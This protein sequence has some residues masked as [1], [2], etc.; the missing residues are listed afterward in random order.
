MSKPGDVD[1]I[2]YFMSKLA[3]DVVSDGQSPV[4]VHKT[5]VSRLPVIAMAVGPIQTKGRLMKK[6]DEKIEETLSWQNKE[7]TDSQKTRA[8]GTMGDQVLTNLAT[9]LGGFVPYVG[10]IE[11]A[12]CLLEPLTK[13]SE[14][15]E[16]CVRDAAVK[17][18]KLV[19]QEVFSASYTNDQDSEWIKRQSFVEKLLAFVLKEHSKDQFFTKQISVCALAAVAFDATK[20]APLQH[21]FS[22]GNVENVQDL[23]VLRFKDLQDGHD[24]MLRRATAEN[25]RDMACVC[26]PERTWKDLKPIWET[27]IHDTQQDSIR[28]HAIKAASCIFTNQTNDGGAMNEQ[29]VKC[30]KSLELCGNDKAWQVRQAV[31]RALPEV[32]LHAKCLDE[33][34][35]KEIGS[36]YMRLLNDQE[37]E[38]WSA[39]ALRSAAAAK[40]FGDAVLTEEIFLT[41]KKH[42]L[43]P[44]QEGL[45]RIQLAES[46]LEMGYPLGPQKSKQFFLTAE[47]EY[48]DKT[49]LNKLFEEEGDTNFRLAIIRKLKALFEEDLIPL[50]NAMDVV[51]KVSEMCRSKNWRIRHGALELTPWVAKNVPTW[52]DPACKFCDDKHGFLMDHCFDNTAEVRRMWVEVSAEIIKQDKNGVEWYKKNVAP[53]L[54]KCTEQ[55]NYLHKA[56]LLNALSKLVPMLKGNDDLF[57]PLI[58][59]ALL[60]ADS[61]VPNLK[62]LV[63]KTLG[64]V[65]D[66]CNPSQQAEITNVLKTLQS[67]ADV[68]VRENALA[69][70]QRST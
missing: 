36:M 22:S 38:V 8:T 12:E 53:V 70:E 44:E 18:I 24:P 6:L 63:A 68:D 49:L 10:G 33:A 37:T 45:R 35:R 3:V 28:S 9:T 25:I 15:H 2:D 1:E 50:A 32:V 19:Y 40:N 13:L 58:S 56:V 4:K 47:W 5:W 51:Y 60:M 43:A 17:S 23:I 14:I 67:D 48:G 31:G 61:T 55:A 65:K 52:A 11:H 16:T 59:N 29:L 42:V 69:A 41:V 54:A 27:F 57:A 46:M 66:Y 39:T 26:G 34:S 64:E 7:G 62:L 20:K 30:W 21:T